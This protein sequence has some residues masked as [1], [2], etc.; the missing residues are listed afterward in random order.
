LNKNNDEFINNID[1]KKFLKSPI[2]NYN[3]LKNSPKN[4]KENK[5]IEF[6]ENKNIEFKEN[7]NIQIND[8]SL[9]E[10]KK[11]KEIKENKNLN[12]IKENKKNDIL[13][14]KN[15]IFL[16]K[17]EHL[18]MAKNFAE[19]SVFND[20]LFSFKNNDNKFKKLKF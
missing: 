6:K 12:E 19:E 8:K 1:T 20:N 9:N 17:N 16:N 14:N 5:N 11:I 18:K 4:F 15:N 3:N 2:M 13:L 10:I 7:K